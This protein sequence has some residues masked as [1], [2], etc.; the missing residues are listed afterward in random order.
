MIVFET[1][2][3]LNRR[4][5]KSVHLT[6]TIVSFSPP[7]S[8]NYWKKQLLVRQAPYVVFIDELDAVG[9]ESGLIKG[10]GGQEPDT[11]LNQLHKRGM[12]DKKDRSLEIWK[13]V[14]INEA[15]MAVSKIAIGPYYCS[16]ST[17]SS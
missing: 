7:N 11:T 14:A 10:A 9:R 17:T 1:Q 12:L 6:H 16:I 8:D 13:Q 5:L 2:L 3:E 4:S 15:A